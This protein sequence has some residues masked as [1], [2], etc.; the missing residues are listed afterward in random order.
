QDLLALSKPTHRL[1]LLELGRLD[2]AV[3]AWFARAA[4]A[5]IETAGLSPA[6]ITAIGSHGQTIWHAPE[7]ELAF[8]MQIGSASRIAAMTGCP[9]VSD[10]RNADMALGGQGAPLVCAFH[11]A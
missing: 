7:E 10:F 1:T 8:S 9:V 2:Q 5:V 3:G 4:N 6:Q 11:A